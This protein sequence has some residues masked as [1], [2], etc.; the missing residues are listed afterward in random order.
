MDIT[1]EIWK[2]IDVA[3]WSNDATYGAWGS[4]EEPQRHEDESRFPRIGRI[5][6]I[7]PFDQKLGSSA[8]FSVSMIKDGLYEEL[9]MITTSNVEFILPSSDQLSDVA[10]YDD[11]FPLHMFGQISQCFL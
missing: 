9:H 2:S 3:Y 11:R 6:V 5:R 10:D 7:L 8:R 1:G 4:H